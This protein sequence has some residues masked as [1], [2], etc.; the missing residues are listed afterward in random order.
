MDNLLGVSTRDL[1]V[2]FNLVGF[3]PTA[4]LAF[5]VVGALLSGAPASGPDLGGLEAHVRRFSPLEA[6]LLTVAVLALALV[7]HPLQLSLVRVLEGYWGHGVVF[8]IPADWGRGRH[9]RRR[10]LLERQTQIPKPEGQQPGAQ[11]IAAASMAAWKLRRLYPDDADHVMPTL[12]G[13]V[14][15]AAEDRA[16][17]RYGLDCVVVWPRLYPM[18]SESLTAALDDARNQLDLMVRFAATFG[19]VALGALVLLAPHGW[20]AAVVLAALVLAWMSYRAGVNA[21]IAYGELLESAIDLHRFDLLQA[22]HLPLPADPEAEQKLNAQ[23]SDLLR[24]DLPMQ[25]GY[26]HAPS[27]E[28]AG[29]EGLPREPSGNRRRRPSAP[30]ASPVRPAA[31]GGAE[32][33]PDAGNRS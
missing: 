24:Q 11:Q 8:R 31:P 25:V 12:L 7:L 20:W 4:L 23:L 15:K 26:V 19:L 30:S 22:L 1:G 5:F 13:N 21:A 14:L 9:R 17:G 33:G 32:K 29:D 27:P 18:L 2:R 16:G 10:E 28:P 6:A 3:L